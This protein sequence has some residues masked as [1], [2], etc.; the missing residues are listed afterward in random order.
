MV[1]EDK[2]KSINI[3]TFDPHLHTMNCPHI[4]TWTTKPL[5]GPIYRIDGSRKIWRYQEKDEINNSV[6]SCS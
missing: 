3:P 1:N 2:F 4:K 5:P 6:F